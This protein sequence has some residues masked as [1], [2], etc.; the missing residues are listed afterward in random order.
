[1][2]NIVGNHTIVH[3]ALRCLLGIAILLATGI[4][5][6]QTPL[7]VTEA[8]I[9]FLPGDGPM[10]GYFVLNN[11]GAQPVTLTGANS[12]AFARVEAHETVERDG[13]ATMRPVESVTVAAGDHVAFQ[14][15]GYH[16]MLMQRQGDIRIGDQL[17]IA[18]RFGDG[19]ELEAMFTVK[20]PW[21]E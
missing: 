15:G 1:M 2:T 10:A 11:T 17:P 8:W 19:A 21:Q 12:P 16:L 7:E 18:L 4:V 5:R 20:A 13:Q 9:R 14:P 6:A 3:P